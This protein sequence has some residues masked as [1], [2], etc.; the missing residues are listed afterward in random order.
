MQADGP[1]E[2]PVSHSIYTLVG[3]TVVDGYE[4]TRMYV[5]EIEYAVP[6]SFSRSFVPKATR[7]FSN[8]TIRMRNGRFFMISALRWET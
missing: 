8:M 1:A 6:P 5:E 2:Y 3:D 4:S 7:S